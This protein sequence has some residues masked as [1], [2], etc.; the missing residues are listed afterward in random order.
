MK[1]PAVILALCSAFLSPALLA[2]VIGVKGDS[3]LWRAD[4]GGELGGVSAST[5]GFS[6]EDGQFFHLYVEHPIPLVPNARLSYTDI[7][8][9]RSETLANQQLAQSRI[10]L[11]H[12][13][14]TAYYELLD[15]WVNLDLGLSVRLFDGAIAF[16]SVAGDQKIELDDGIPMGYLLAEAELPFT[17]W[18]AG[19]ELNYTEYDD[20]TISD[21]TVKLRYL[22]DAVLD[23]GFEVGYR[24]FT[25][26]LDKGFGADTD[27]SGPYA[28]FAAQF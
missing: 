28:A 1:K 4:F 14:A 2:D 13:D 22:F 10:D 25:L 3:G 26:D 18:S 11:S 17:G 6:D 20:Y 24:E 19:A 21:Y 5:L 16:D 7:S 8:A 12:V 9:E 15:N 23:V 27:L